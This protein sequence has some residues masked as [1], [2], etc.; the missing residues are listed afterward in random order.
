MVGF[1]LP[2]PLPLKAKKK[3]YKPQT[4]LLFLTNAKEIKQEKRKPARKY[5]LK[6]K[7]TTTVQ[8]RQASYTCDLAAVLIT[9]GWIQSFEPPNSQGNLSLAWLNSNPSGWLKE[10]SGRLK[11]KDK[12]GK[13]VSSRERENGIFTWEN[14]LGQR[15]E[16]SENYARE[17]TIRNKGK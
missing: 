12:A 10:Y 7:T 11:V 3:S 8:M 15:A 9:Y 13:K 6:M 17:K 14:E 4:D 1:R 2:E 5:D 16:T